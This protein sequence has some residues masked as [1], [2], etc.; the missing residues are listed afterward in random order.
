MDFKDTKNKNELLTSIDKL[1]NDFSSVLKTDVNAGDK[2]Y[3]K[4]ALLYYWLRDYKNYIKNESKF[5]SKYLPAYE[6]GAIVNVNFGFNIGNEFG[7]LHYAVVLADSGPANPN[8]IVLP[9]KS[10][11][12]DISSL[13]KHELFLGNEL[14]N[15]LY[16][17][18]VALSTAL[19][20]Q[21]EELTKRHDVAKKRAAALKALIDEKSTPE[22]ELSQLVD[23]F[24][25][26]TA[27]IL[28]EVANAQTKDE[29][30]KRLIKELHKMKIG[31][32]ALMDQIK[33]ISKM[34]IKNPINKQDIL[35]GIKLSS[36]NLTKIDNKIIEIYTNKH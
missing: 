18:C 4:A 5:S 25:K 13:H 28:D 36:E 20:L 30:I 33:T 17:N 1:F 21:L 11:K 8:V 16:G 3:K 12:K 19:K 27:D 34:R 14:Y 24:S 10:L 9:L 15:R 7:G 32:V 26:E 6:R 22:P 23:S 35:Y 29:K 31:S 2:N